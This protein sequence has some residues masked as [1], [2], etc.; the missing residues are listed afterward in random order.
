MRDKAEMASHAKSEFLAN[1]SH[2]IRTPMNGII[3]MTDMLK[4]SGLTPE[5]QQYADIITSSGENLM[6]IINDILDFSK[7]EAAQMELNPA[8]FDLRRMVEEVATLVAPKTDDAVDIATFVD[9]VLPDRVVGDSVRV[10]QVLLNMVGNAAKFTKTGSVLVSV[11]EGDGG[12]DPARISLSF[13]VVDTGIAPDK[14]DTMFDKFSQATSGTSKLYGGTGLGLAICKDLVSLMDGAVFA[15]SR[16]GEG[17]VFG[18]DVSLPV[19]GLNDDDAHSP[20]FSGLA[21]RR[22]ELLTRSAA[23]HWSLQALFVR[24]G[25]AVDS[26]ADTAGSLARIVESM[27]SGQGADLLVVDARVTTQGGTPIAKASSALP[28]SSGVSV[29][30]L[31]GSDM[32]LLVPVRSHAL[33]ERTLEVLDSSA[34]TA[35]V[36]SAEGAGPS[37]PSGPPLEPALQPS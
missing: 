2:E 36:Q 4:T 16:P 24:Y 1:M 18:F 37:E 13:R 27:R 32:D 9:P 8:P 31:G 12:G 34:E 33:L 22:V 10:R 35:S 21:G 25:A 26:W 15:R 29:V 11:T 3:G 28:A 23:M 19:A 5:Q 14:L 20:S 7:L 6:T 30:T 17:S